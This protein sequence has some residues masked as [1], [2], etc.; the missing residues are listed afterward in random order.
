M[1]YIQNKKTKEIF[2]VMQN[3]IIEKEE[4]YTIINEIDY[5]KTDFF[6]N[7]YRARKIEEIKNFFQKM[8]EFKVVSKDKSL[9]IVA[10][11]DMQNNINS[12]VASMKYDISA[13]LIT[14]DLASF[15]YNNFVIPYAKCEELRLYISKIRTTI[16]SAESFHIGDNLSLPNKI[17][18]LLT[19]QQIDDYNY[20][21]DS[22]GQLITQQ[23]DFLI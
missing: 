12:W 18:T 15:E 16:K 6:L 7:Q 19:K 1:K 3:A 5:F 4:D 11:Q 8:R 2:Q 21:V 23:K 14:Q 9:T 17:L 10:N 22:K 13:K 20:R